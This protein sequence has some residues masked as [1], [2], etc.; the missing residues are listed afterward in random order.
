MSENPKGINLSPEN[1]KC[2]EYQLRITQLEAQI[3]DMSADHDQSTKAIK[4]LTSELRQQQVI[5][6]KHSDE[7]KLRDE[8][9]EALRG[10]LSACR[11]EQKLNNVTTGPQDGLQSLTATKW[12]APKEDRY[13]RDE[14]FKIG[15]RIR[16][17]ARNNSASFT[18]LDGVATS[19]TDSAV[20]YL[21][22][23]CAVR[24]WKALINKFPVSKDKAPALLVQ[25][26]LAKDL[27]ERLFKD[28]FFAF[29][30]I[31]RDEAM[32]RPA[33]MRVLQDGIT[34]V[35]NDDAHIWRSQTIRSL[36]T[37]KDPETQPFLAARIE[38]VCRQ[39]ISELLSSPIRFLLRTSEKSTQS[40]NKWVEELLSLYKV[41]AQLALILWGQRASIAVRTLDELPLFRIGDEEVSAHRLHHLDEEDTRLDGKKALLLVQPAILAFGSESAEHYDQ[42]KV[43]APAVVLLDTQ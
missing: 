32:P 8:T 41:A 29:I 30:A 2:E 17:W 35:S 11:E 39:F 38:P 6:E 28:P 12:H 5:T 21:S 13:A 20:K 16:Q 40:Y 10:E 42:H 27:F 37:A 18:D 1:L 24:D 23:Y 19:D 3:Q 22:G 14:L 34:R 4:D 15:D 25:A 43:W 26:I 33:Q 7:L 31:E 9:I 36:S